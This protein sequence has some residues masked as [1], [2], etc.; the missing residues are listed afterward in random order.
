V[1]DPQ[2]SARKNW[3]WSDVAMSSLSHRVSQERLGRGAFFPPSSHLH[4]AYL[5][6]RPSL[7]SL[8]ADFYRGLIELLLIEA[9][10]PI[11]RP[12]TRG[13]CQAPTLSSLRP[14]L[15]YPYSSLFT[16]RCAV[17]PLRPVS[18]LFSSI[19]DAPGVPILTRSLVN[20]FSSTLVFIFILFPFLQYGR[21]Q[22]PC[23]PHR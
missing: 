11:S 18:L 12:S 15:F 7:L 6:P 14:P 1:G 17:F 3:S 4:S 2:R 20:V 23:G 13:F 9:W 22:V 19:Q 16:R 8:L 5:S 21:I 10:P